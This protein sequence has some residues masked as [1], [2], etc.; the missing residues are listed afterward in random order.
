M[1]SPA[2]QNAAQALLQ[3]ILSILSGLSPIA[4]AVVSACTGLVTSLVNMAFAGS[5]DTTSI[6]VLAAGAVS[7][8]LVY[9][10]PN[11][12]AVKPAPT[13]APTPLKK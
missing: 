11:K 9:A 8:I 4:K 10:V 3:Q 13:P 5:F 2:V 7:A 1:N 6:V 12:A